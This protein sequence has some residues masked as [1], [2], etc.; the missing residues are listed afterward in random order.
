MN[1]NILT[2]AVL[3][4][5]ASSVAMATNYTN[6]GSSQY[7]GIGGTISASAVSGSSSSVGSNSTGNGYQAAGGYAT[8]VTSAGASSTPMLGGVAVTAHTLSQGTSGTYAVGQGEGVGGA[9]AV[10]GGMA[11]ANAVG[12]VYNV[13]SN[14]HRRNFA[15]G[16]GNV[17]VTSSATQASGAISANRNDGESYQWSGAGAYNDTIGYAQLNANTRPGASIESATGIHTTGETWAYGDGYT[18]N[19]F[20]MSGGISMQDGGGKAV[21]NGKERLRKLNNYQKGKARSVSK[22]NINGFSIAGGVGNHEDYTQSWSGAGNDSSADIAAKFKNNGVVQQTAT[23]SDSYE[24]ANTS[25]YGNSESDTEADAKGIG[26]AIG[27]FNGG[28]TP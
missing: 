5:T 10:Q 22:A 8:N 11:N 18:D 9:I 13:N 23:N 20:G 21:A 16:S 12:S 24:Y 26:I 15:G 6:P 17:N 7:S 19:A 4:I 2:I 28:N 3:T 25:G 27:G 1:K 14:H